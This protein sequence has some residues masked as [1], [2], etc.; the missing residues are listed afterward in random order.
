VTSPDV[1]QQLEDSGYG[2]PGFAARYDAC[3]PQTPAFLLELLRRLARASRPAL[4]VDLGAGTGL[5]TRCWADVADTVV[6]VEPNRAMREYA[7]NVTQARNVT[8]VDAVASD[9]GLAEGSADIVTCSQSLQWM[10]PVSTFAEIGR[11]LRSGGVFAAYQY[12]SLQTEC[13]EAGAAFFERLDRARHLRKE[14]DLDH[15]RI[16]WPVTSE[17]LADSGCFRYV[18]ELRAHS[19]ESGNA[20]RLVGLVQSTGHITTLLEHVSESEIGLDRLREVVDRTLGTDGGTWW[21]GYR[22]WLGLK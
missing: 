18:N 15:D 16:R 8:Y 17:G 10:E 19:V 3:K 4:V 11:I 20:D 13:W 12:D 6:G 14:L 7:E 9:T 21:F 1:T 22:V 5:S 2:V